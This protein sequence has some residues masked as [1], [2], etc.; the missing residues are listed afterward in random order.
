MTSQ[1]RASRENQEIISETI[2]QGTPKTQMMTMVTAK[3]PLR[4]IAARMKTPLR[5]RRTEAPDMMAVREAK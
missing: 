4:K 1:E 2:S 5:T 3:M